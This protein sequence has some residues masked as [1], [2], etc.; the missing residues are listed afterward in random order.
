MFSFKICGLWITVC[1]NSSSRFDSVKKFEIRLDITFDVN[2]LLM[3]GRL[4]ASVFNIL[5][6][7]LFSS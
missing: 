5:F 3:F 6:I 1:E 4:L 2:I 7:K